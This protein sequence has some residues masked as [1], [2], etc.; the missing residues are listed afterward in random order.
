MWR[1]GFSGVVLACSFFG[2]AFGQTSDGLVAWGSDEWG[3][4]TVPAGDDFVAI[5]S[6]YDFNVAL[7]E[8][9]SLVAWGRDYVWGPEDWNP[10]AVPSGNDFVAI[11]DSSGHHSLAI[12]ADGSLAAWGMNDQGQRDVPAGNDFV[13]TSAGYKHSLALEADGSIVAWGTN[14]SCV[15]NT[16]AGN[17]FVAISAG[18]YFSV[19]LKQDGSLVAWGANPDGRCDVPPGN[20][21]VAI[22][23][24]SFHSL[25]LRAD[26]SLAAW[27]HNGG[28]R[29]D[30]PEGNDFVAIAAGGSHSLALKQDGSVVAWGGNSHGQ[31]NVPPGNDFLAIGAGYYHSVALQITN[32]SPV[33]DAGP[34][35]TVE[36]SG[37][38]TAVTLDGTPSFDPDGDALGFEWSLPE[39]SGAAIDDPSSATPHGQFPLGPTLVTL[40]VTDGN[41]G[42]DV[43][44]V[45]IT[46]IDTVPPVLVATTDKIALWPPN[47][48][49]HEVLVSVE[50]TDCAWDTGVT[51]TAW[52]FSS[53]P[54]DATGDGSY[55]GDV[56]GQDGY[57]AP[58]PVD[59]ICTGEPQP[60]V[61][62]Y[63]GLVSLRAERD[64]S[65]S[66]R[67]YS[68]VCDIADL[69]GNT[70][71]AS[72]VVVV[73]H[74]R[75]KK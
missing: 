60:G 73:P 44:D 41:G 5:A 56:D 22:D 11:S 46:V 52:V 4:V 8:D 18:C 20:D 3:Q 30:V 12:R 68:I 58:V 55:T 21:F 47:H 9:G 74:D 39:G 7:K 70:N 65:E 67:V 13:A 16:P 38:L 40:T 53:E 61:Y 17:D 54:D 28:G 62:L 29:C 10:C 43:A 50:L 24:G 14:E 31:G 48:E 37:P 33:A 57:A 49:M 42:V 45:L 51:L 35:Q 27:G 34:P 72:C 19:A 63:E 1:I 59:L 66:S 71:T 15:W 36:C 23:A 6:G 32:Q 75:R 25:A 26:G 2:Q 64:G 69:A